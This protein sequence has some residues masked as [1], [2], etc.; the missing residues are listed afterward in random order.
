MGT[1]I[2]NG[3]LV[4]PNGEQQLDILLENGV[5][6]NIG[7]NLN[8]GDNVVYDAKGALVFAGFIDSHTHLDMDTGTALTSDN[9]YTGTKAALAGGTTSIIDFATQEKGQTLAEALDIW[10]KKANGKA[11][12][13][14]GFHMAI[15]NINNDVKS[16]IATL[17]KNGVTSFKLYMAYDALRVTDREIYDILEI[18]KS[19]GGIVGVHCENGDLVNALIAKMKSHG[20]FF[21]SAHPKSRPSYV[22]AEAITR[23]CAIAK[24][25]DAA[26]NVVHVSSAQGL[27]AIKNAKKQGQIIFTESCPQYFTCFEDKYDLQGFESAKYVC[28]PP[29]RNIKDGEALWQALKNDEIDTLA[30]DHCAFMFNTQKVQGLNDFSKIPNGMPGIEH[31]AAVMLTEGLHHHGIAPHK[32]AKLLSENSAKIFGLSKTKGSL[33]VGKDADIVVWDKNK[34]W[35]ITAENML[36]NVDYTPFEGYNAKGKAVAVFLNGK[37]VFENDNILSQRQ[38]KFLLR[39]KTICL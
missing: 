32:M 9:F 8:A 18:V 6:A 37:L 2:K 31:R 4:L 19:C 23:F 5:I 12:C 29:L 21:P 27:L 28:S 38:G 7:A 3:V 17:C 20:N 33:E 26:I 16:E 24:A 1:I 25:A 39:D 14:Y 11:S 15:T 22:E 13:N 36:Q 10:H 35:T 30:T 34:S